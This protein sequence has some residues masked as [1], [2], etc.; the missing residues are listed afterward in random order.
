MPAVVVPGG[1]GVKVGVHLRV[2]NG[3]KFVFF[4]THYI[5]APNKAEKYN[6][7]AKVYGCNRFN[8]PV[9]KLY[10]FTVV[11]KFC[12]AFGYHE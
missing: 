11:F 1:A 4:G 12:Y 5:F 3:L 8:N 10:A 7:R 2:L 6:A 9:R